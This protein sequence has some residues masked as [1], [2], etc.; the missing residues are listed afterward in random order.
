MLDNDFLAPTAPLLATPAAHV[1]SD[2]TVARLSR[3]RMMRYLTCAG[4]GLQ[5]PFTSQAQGVGA[6]EVLPGKAPFEFVWSG[7]WLG[8]R[9]D[10]HGAMPVQW[11]SVT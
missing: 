7:I 5:L 6:V 4:L 8:S 9:T 10:P 3:R 1:D 2:Q 11:A